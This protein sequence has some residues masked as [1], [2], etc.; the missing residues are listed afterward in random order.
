MTAKERL[1]EIHHT[2]IEAART[3][4]N[5]ALHKVETHEYV[6]A[7][8]YENIT[9]Q[10]DKLEKAVA[11]VSENTRILPWKFLVGSITVCTFLMGVIMFAARI[12]GMK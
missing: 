11:A 12:G 10:L 7:E 6:C 3:V 5:V 4:A 8:R 9:K 2:D 1:V